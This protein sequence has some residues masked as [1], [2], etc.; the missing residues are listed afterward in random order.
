MIMSLKGF[1]E[2]IE[3][4]K[5]NVSFLY[6]ILKDRSVPIDEQLPLCQSMPYQAGP[7]DWETEIYNIQEFLNQ[8]YLLGS[9]HKHFKLD[10]ETVEKMLAAYDRGDSPIK[11]IM[12]TI[13]TVTGY[14][15]IESIGE[16]YGLDWR[17]IAE[18]NNVSPLDIVAGDE[19]EIPYEQNPQE[20]RRAFENLLVFDVPENIK[21]LGK[22]FPDELC[23]DPSTG[24]LKIFNHRETFEQGIKNIIHTEPGGLPLWPNYG[25]NHTLNQDFPE[26]VRYEMLKVNLVSALEQ[27]ARIQRVPRENIEIDRTGDALSITTQIVPINNLG[28]IELTEEL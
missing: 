28:Y 2:Q 18:F 17:D 24:D 12:S 15:T 8:L 21:V 14:D 23:V 26:D 10:R 6:G 19:L 27:D 22:D 7:T 9:I 3:T 25:F 16:K 13:H 11:V 5:T 1:Y 20:A 4:A